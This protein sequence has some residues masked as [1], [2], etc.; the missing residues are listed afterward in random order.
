M[1]PTISEFTLMFAIATSGMLVLALAIVFFVLFYQK[2]MLANKL[3]QQQLESEYQQKMLLA[4]LQSQESERRRIAG[5]LHDSIGAM[6]SAVRV[7]LSTLVRKEAQIAPHVEQTKKILDETIDSVRRISRDLMPSTLEKFGLSFALKE[8]C[9]QYATVSGVNIEFAQEGAPVPVDKSKEVMIFRIVQEFFN[10]SLKHSAADR[11][12]LSMNW[13]P[14]LNIVIEDNGKG[15]DVR[16]HQSKGLGLFNMENRA[17]IIQA[18]L[19]I[20]SEPGQG[21]RAMLTIPMAS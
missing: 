2:R 8:M 12:L 5:D 3:R 9:E 7:S 10:N 6:L 15:F 18:A 1:E 16:E 13:S 17:R 20:E 21:T 14:E 19:N 11:I 4:S